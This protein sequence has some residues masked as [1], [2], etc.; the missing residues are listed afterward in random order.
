MGPHKLDG[1]AYRKTKKV[2][3]KLNKEWGISV[4]TEPTNYILVCNAGLTTGSTYE[5]LVELFEKYGIIEDLLLLPDK[6][7]SFLTF[8]EVDAA[9]KAF[10]A[11]HANMPLPSQNNVLY[12]SYVSNIPNVI[13]P[14]SMWNQGSLVWPNGL[15][16]LNEFVNE[17]EEQ[18][19]L[20]SLDWNI[21]TTNPNES[22]CGLKHRK[23]LHFGYEFSYKDNSE[24]I[25]LFSSICITALHL[26]NLAPAS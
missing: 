17:E 6:S 5:E 14:L 20:N 1:K 22:K 12:L 21:N 26:A 25:F 4:E 19:L 7:Y 23:V 10:K 3:D 11:V 2:L 15:E 24:G 8:T 18:Q 13:N 16:I 9:S